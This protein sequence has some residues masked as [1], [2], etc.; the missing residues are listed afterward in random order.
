MVGANDFPTLIQEL[1]SELNQ[2]GERW[3]ARARDRAGQAPI[4]VR[5]PRMGETRSTLV[6]HTRGSHG[7]SLRETRGSRAP[8]VDG[9]PGRA[10]RRAATRHA[11]LR[12]SLCGA[13]YARACITR[14][15]GSAFDDAPES[16]DPLNCFA[17]N[18]FAFL[19]RENFL[20]T[21]ARARIKIAMNTTGRKTVK[22]KATA[23][24]SVKATARASGRRARRASRPSPSGPTRSISRA[25]RSRDTRSRTGW[26]PKPS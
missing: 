5:I 17:L 23:A 16:R 7:R 9:D 13:I 6:V 15:F 20:A 8:L 26:P 10:A 19:T 25:A 2:D 1:H 12:L 22:A 21:R 4:P 18:C 3:A 11:R 24:K 14:R